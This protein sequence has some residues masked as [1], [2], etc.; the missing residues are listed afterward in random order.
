MQHA[1][2]VI[3]NVFLRDFL[4]VGGAEIRKDCVRDGVPPPVAVYQFTGFLNGFELALFRCAIVFVCF[5]RLAVVFFVKIKR[6]ALTRIVNVKVGDAIG[7]ECRKL[8]GCTDARN[9]DYHVF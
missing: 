5:V 2:D 8:F 4:F 3:K 9:R 6:K 1:I 7:Y